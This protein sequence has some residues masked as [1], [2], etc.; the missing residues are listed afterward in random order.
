[1]WILEETG[2]RIAGQTRW[3]HML[4]STALSNIR[5]GASRGEVV[6]DLAGTAVHDCCAP[7][8]KLEGV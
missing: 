8:F 3:L 4:C 7:Y 5:V 6:S 1:M 2:F